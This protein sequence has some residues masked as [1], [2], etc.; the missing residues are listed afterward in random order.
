M[1]R[2]NLEI[3]PLRR[4][5]SADQH[6]PDTCQNWSSLAAS[7]AVRLFLAR[8][9]GEGEGASIACASENFASCSHARYSRIVKV[10]PSF[11]LASMFTAKI[12]G[13]NAGFRSSSGMISAISGRPGGPESAVNARKKVLGS[14]CGLAVANVSEQRH[15]ETRFAEVHFEEISREVVVSFGCS[16]RAYAALNEDIFNRE[17]V[18]AYCNECTISGENRSGKQELRLTAIALCNR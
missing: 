15:V 11:V 3:E 5:S 1:P 18:R 8:K 17:C 16:F 12:I 10:S 4:A 13:V 14:P 6:P 9:R 2:A 7:K